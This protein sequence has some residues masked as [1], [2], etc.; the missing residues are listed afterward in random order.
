MLLIKQRIC[1]F[2]VK[3][4][5]DPKQ[6]QFA[7][8]SWPWSD[9]RLHRLAVLLLDEL[10]G[11]LREGA[12]VLLDCRELVVVRITCL[13]H[14]LQWHPVLEKSTVMGLRGGDRWLAQENE[15]NF[16]HNSRKHTLKYW[17][18]FHRRVQVLV[19][20]SGLFGYWVDLVGSTRIS[21]FRRR[22]RVDQ[23]GIQPTIPERSHISYFRLEIYEKFVAFYYFTGLS[24]FR[25]L[26]SYGLVSDSWGESFGVKQKPKFQNRTVTRHTKIQ[27][28]HGTAYGPQIRRGFRIW[29]Q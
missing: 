2:V 22:N 15:M 21:D 3:D 11:V 29:T 4:F 20:G 27:K 28:V 25:L 16:V 18:W 9:P 1:F 23:W 5:I 13:L 7:R 14:P 26:S 10:V 8:A 17:V 6:S 24:K 19:Y 12:K